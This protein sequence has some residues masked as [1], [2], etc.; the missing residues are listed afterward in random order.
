L[1]SCGVWCGKVLISV[2]PACECKRTVWCLFVVTVWPIER[3]QSR[4]VVRARM[5]ENMLLWAARVRVLRRRKCAVPALHVV[6]TC[7]MTVKVRETRHAV[8]R[9]QR[10]AR[11]GRLI[12]GT[13]EATL[14][15]L[16]CAI[17]TSCARTHMAALRANTRRMTRKCMGAT[18]V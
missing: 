8:N 2:G 6:A 18:H 9:H 11:C 10:L 3:I 15:S 7:S 4:A 13:P 5:H 1:R 17:S 12:K 16:R 14:T